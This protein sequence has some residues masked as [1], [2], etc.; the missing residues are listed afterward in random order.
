MNQTE[1][2]KK[3]AR[4]GTTQLIAKVTKGNFKFEEL[5]DIFSVLEKRN[6]DFA[7]NGIDKEA[8]MPSEIKVVT[9]PTSK[10][11]PKKEKVARKSTKNP[12]ITSEHVAV[13]DEVEFE[14]KFHE[15]LTGKVVKIYDC[16]R[17][18]KPFVRINA[19][20]KVYHKLLSY[21]MPKEEEVQ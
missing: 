8:L 1:T 21:F 15:K 3:I 18:G 14:N 4:Q 12:D 2:Y 16:N 5:N 20:G 7:A 9:K 17:T 19:N 10:K 11:A 6:V 13:G